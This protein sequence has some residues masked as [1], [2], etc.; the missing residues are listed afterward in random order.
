MSIQIFKSDS[1]PIPASELARNEHRT[2]LYGR[3]I[4]PADYE[5]QYS[6]IYAAEYQGYDERESPQAVEIDRKYHLVKKPSVY[7]PEKTSASL[8]ETF[9]WLF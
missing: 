3:T 8:V 6:E 5:K 4:E 1:L 9:E 7:S 2:H